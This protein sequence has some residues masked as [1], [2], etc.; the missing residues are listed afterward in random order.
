MDCIILY[1]DSNS[2]EPARTVVVQILHTDVIVRKKIRKIM[3]KPR[4]L[5]L[6]LILIIVFSSLLS[7]NGYALSPPIRT[8]P[9]DVPTAKPVFNPNNNSIY[10]PTYT[11]D[12]SGHAVVSGQL[13]EISV[14]SGNQKS[15]LETD[16]FMRVAINPKTNIVYATTI[17][18]EGVYQSGEKKNGLLYVIDG[19]NN[20]VIEEIDL[21]YNPSEI[22]VNP[23]TDQVYLVNGMDKTIE[24]FDGSTI[25]L[26]KTIEVG[27]TGKLAINSNENLIYMLSGSKIYVIDELTATVD[28]TIQVSKATMD[29]AFN[30]NTDILYV[31]DFRNNS[32]TVIDTLTNKVVDVIN[33]GF[34]S[35]DI[36]IN[37]NTNSIF[38]A[39]CGNSLVSVIDGLTN[40]LMRN[41]KV[42]EFP[43]GLI[44]N[45]NN[46]EVYVYTSGWDTYSHIGTF[47]TDGTIIHTIQDSSILPSLTPMQQLKDGILPRD[48]YCPGGQV[49]IIKNSG[50]IDCTAR[51]EVE[52][53]VEKEDGKEVIKGEFIDIA[54]IICCGTQVWGNNYRLIPDES[55]KSKIGNLNKASVLLSGYHLDPNHNDK[56]VSIQGILVNDYEEY[57]CQNFSFYCNRSS[58]ESKPRIYINVIDILGDVLKKD[59]RYSYNAKT[60]TKISSLEIPEK[61]AFEVSVSCEF[62]EKN[63]NSYCY[64]LEKTKKLN[65]TPRAKSIV[66]IQPGEIYRTSAHCTPTEQ[67]VNGAI[68]KYSDSLKIL[69]GELSLDDPYDVRPNHWKSFN[70]FYVTVLNEGEESSRYIVSAQ[71]VKIENIP[72]KKLM[73]AGISVEDV[74]CNYDLIPIY[75]ISKYTVACVKPETAQK[76]VERT[77]GNLEWP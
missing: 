7:N 40:S 58:D 54:G 59:T 72:P 49:A 62:V 14:K 64:S 53:I 8:T 60:T 47:D 31:I 37:E 43:K 3:I 61:S 77:W 45:S 13:F 23:K 63:R 65:P 71:C 34:E 76:L 33:V 10:F 51:D 27:T 5:I 55:E 4:F 35:T 39:N 32:V 68:I 25:R 56:R 9:C 11:Y 70:S 36:A 28:T 46:D 67:A 22:V 75:K 6:A 18:V 38:V 74:E 15:F 29:L 24:I 48:L 26:E 69:S 12:A 20:K 17:F 42:E 50:S 1:R 52:S 30:P 16:G 66:T 21:G 44:V 41:E 57:E 19:I 2:F 73:K